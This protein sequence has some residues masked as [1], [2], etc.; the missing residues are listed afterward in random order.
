LTGDP[1]SLAA[2]LAGLG[3]APLLGPQADRTLVEALA[4]EPGVAARLRAVIDDPSTPWPARFLS[5]EFLFRHVDLTALQQCDRAKLRDAY[6][7]ALRHNTTRNGTD[8]G[9]AK[10]PNDLGALSRM[11]LDF[12]GGGEPFERGL[13]DDS[14]VVMRFS[15]GTPPHFAPPY[16]VKDFAALIVANARRLPIDLSGPPEQRD[17]AIEGLA[18]EIAAGR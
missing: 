7:Q 4:H 14:P 16:R 2:R 5:S 13:A 8:W 11:V 17:R 12:G 3:Y 1:E 9:F 18:K 10:G 15:W 6:F